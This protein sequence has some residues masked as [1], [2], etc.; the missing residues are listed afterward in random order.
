MAKGVVAGALCGAVVAVGAAAA[1][2]LYA[3]GPDG[4]ASRSPTNLAERPATTLTAPPAERTAPLAERTE[5]S[6]ETA[7]PDDP[8]NMPEMVAPLPGSSDPDDRPAGATMPMADAL[9]DTPPLRFEDSAPA[10]TVAGAPP[11]P[12][13]RPGDETGVSVSQADPLNPPEAGGPDPQIAADTLPAGIPDASQDSAALAQPQTDESTGR[14]SVTTEAPVMPTVQG[15]EPAAPQPEPEPSVTTEP[16]QPPM[17]VVPTEESGL[18]VADADAAGAPSLPVIEP[19]PEQAPEQAPD[20][21]ST[22]DVAAA[23]PEVQRPA[24]GTPGTTLIER[25][26]QGG[27]LPSIGSDSGEFVP[28]DLPEP[29]LRRYAVD[30]AIAG[31]LPLMSIVLLDDPGGPLGP[32]ELEDFP[33]PLTFAIDPARPGASAR[34]AGYRAQGFEVVVLGA[35]PEGAQ[36]SD[37]E[38]AMA[39]TLAAVPEAVAVLEPP[40][41]GM[42]SSRQ[43]SDQVAQIVKD[44]GHG[45]VLMPNGLN[46]AQALATREGVSAA[47][48]FRDFDQDGQDARTIRRFLDGAAFRARQ[49]GDVI[50]LGRLRADTISALLLWGLQDR[51]SQVALVPVSRVL[52]SGADPQ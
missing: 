49:N 45:L 34:M 39:A 22:P 31:D 18:V 36:A 16:A 23:G 28:S 3:D 50:M 1:L 6:A 47:T 40:R 41:G 26:G 15:M 10:P 4:S 46:T 7:I 21:D 24:I 27:R 43:V 11:A 14:V 5:T 20:A 19:T 2:S 42:Q 17:P 35:V 30:V 38:V 32:E 25:G 8:A 13:L 52:T 44:S 9:P 48:V 51:A 37:V 33:F 12:A 29:P